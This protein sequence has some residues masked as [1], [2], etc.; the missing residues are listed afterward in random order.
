MCK[1][2]HAASPS[3]QPS[4]TLM[5]YEYR[6]RQPRNIGRHVQVSPLTSPHIWFS[7]IFRQ[8]NSCGHCRWL[9]LIDYLFYWMAMRT[10]EEKVAFCLYNKIQKVPGSYNALKSLQR[11]KPVKKLTFN[12]KNWTWSLFPYD[13][14]LFLFWVDQFCVVGFS[15]FRFDALTFSK[16]IQKLLTHAL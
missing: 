8:Y 4:V 10:L 6:Y 5:L 9:K 12:I 13:S 2:T 14:K 15:S 7:Q 1:E 11:D 16:N 3:T